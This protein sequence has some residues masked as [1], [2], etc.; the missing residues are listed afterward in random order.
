MPWTTPLR[1][2]SIA[3]SQAS[4][5]RSWSAK[6]ASGMTPALLTSTSIGAEPLDGAGGRPRP[7]PALLVTSAVTATA[8]AAGVDDARR[9]LRRGVTVDVG[10]HDAAPRAAAI[11]GRQPAEAAARPGDDDHLA[12]EVVG[13]ALAAVPRHRSTP[14]PLGRPRCRRASP[15]PPT[16]RRS[17]PPGEHAGGGSRQW[18]PPQPPPRRIVGHGGGGAAGCRHGGTVIFWGFGGVRGRGLG[19]PWRWGVGC[20][21]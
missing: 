21:S 15:S 2:M 20:G 11:C 18:R 1:L 7:C 4:Q 12:R 10:R 14:S 16:P 5:A 17:P 9:G 8:C 3:R 13:F 19:W 6:N